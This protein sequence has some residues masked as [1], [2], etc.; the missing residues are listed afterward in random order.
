VDHGAASC[1]QD[2]QCNGNGA[3]RLYASGTVCAPQTCADGLFSPARSCDGVGSCGIPSPRSCA[4]YTCGAG[5]TCLTTCA[6]NADCHPGLTCQGGACTGAPAD[7]GSTEPVDAGTGGTGG[8]AGGSGGSGGGGG[9]LDAGAAGGSGGS[10]GSG[11]EV[12]AGETGGTGGT[13]GTAG[14]GGGSGSDGTG[15]TG[16]TAGTGGVGGTMGT[17]D[18]DAGGT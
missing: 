6:T 5:Q 2:G 4:P 16:G 11:G 18:L 14:S 9:E 7:A 15:G 17:V 1:G 3:C 12:D 8:G 10:G 13:G